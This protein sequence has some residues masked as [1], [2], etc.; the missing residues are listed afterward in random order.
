MT[1]R[2]PKPEDAA[3]V[4]ALYNHYVL[5]STASFET[6]PLDAEQMRSRLE[7]ATARLVCERERAIVGFGYTHDWKE[8]AAYRHTQEVTVY[9]A[10][11]S[12]GLG[13]G[14]RLVER[15]VAE[16]RT[17]ECMRWSPASPRTTTRAAGSSNPS[18]SAACRISNRWGVN[19][20]AGW[21]SST[22]NCC[23]ETPVFR[24]SGPKNPADGGKSRGIFLL[25][26]R[27]ASF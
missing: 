14:R 12:T 7:S 26:L 23:S 27:E 21:T 19:S 17:T 18:D 5:H 4:A 20:A 1:I 10:P 6:E 25:L 9:V 11:D 15:L 16:C 8:R 2:A 13:I 3:A 22:T 24:R